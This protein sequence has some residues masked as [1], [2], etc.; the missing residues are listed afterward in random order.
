MT[1]GKHGPPS[2]MKK[3]K[4][5]NRKVVLSWK[6]D[7][8]DPLEMLIADTDL[9]WYKAKHPERTKEEID[10]ISSLRPE[11]CPYCNSTSYIK[12]GKR[13]GIPVFLCKACG[14]RFKALTKTIFDSS[15]IPISEWYEFFLHLSQFHSVKT[16]ASDNRNASNT[17]FMWYRKI[18]LVL[19]G[20]QDDVVLS[21][22]VWFDETFFP[23][24]RSNEIHKDGKNLR[25]IS[26]N[27]ICVG[28]AV[29]EQGRK[30]MIVEWTSKASSKST[31]SA[32]GKHILEGSTLI[33]DGENSHKN[34]IERLGL[35][36]E[37][38]PTALTKGLPDEDNPLRKIN[39]LHAL[40]KRFMEQH[41]GYEREHLQ[42]WMNLIWFILSEPSTVAEKFKIFVKRAVSL[43]KTLRFDMTLCEKRLK[44]E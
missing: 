30:R 35:K 28:V 38:Y 18:F 22:K 9:S 7:S 19:E 20:I 41:G 33:H 43:C 15:K 24:I 2:H 1:S 6:E 23:V 31:L 5:N 13:K 3:R 4:G 8:K 16:S 12:Y 42:D 39:D 25:G 26:R 10:F 32:F 11:S 37:T 36:S 17:G 40:M 34:L 21:G 14:R 29:D 44:H 27:K